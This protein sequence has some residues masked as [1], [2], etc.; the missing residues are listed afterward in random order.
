MAVSSEFWR[1]VT[2]VET[3]LVDKNPIS[4]DPSNHG[5]INDTQFLPEEIRATDAFSVGPEVPD[6]FGHD[7]GLKFRSL[8]SEDTKITRDDELVNEVNP[9]PGLSSLVRV[10]RP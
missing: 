10:G 4:D 6:P 3:L 2:P 1:D 9:D 5:E 7:G 8:G